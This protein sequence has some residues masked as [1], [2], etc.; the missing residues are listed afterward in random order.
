VIFRLFLLSFALAS[1]T[2]HAAEDK[3]SSAIPYLG[4]GSDKLSAEEYERVYKTYIQSSVLLGYPFLKEGAS[5]C[6][7]ALSTIFRSSGMFGYPVPG[8]AEQVKRSVKKMGA[9]KVE[10]FETAGVIIQ[11]ARNA[12]TNALERLLLVNSSSTKA[13]RRLS[14]FAKNELL[15]LEKDPI[16][17]LEKVR[18]LPVGFPHPFL[19]NEGQGLFVKVLKFNGKLEGCQPVDFQDNAWAAGFDLSE[20]RCDGLQTDA[21]KVWDAQLSPEDFSQNELKRMKEIALKAAIA[22]GTKESEALALI[23]KHFQP[24]FTSEINVVGSAMRNLAQCNLLALG[25]AGK[26]RASGAVPKNTEPAESGTGSA[27]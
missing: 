18:G 8:D 14:G 15:S 3:K 27:K 19:T 13:S 5:P 24:P 11:V 17:G 21:A 23:E 25:R 22:K 12:K 16:T 9:N 26:P 4:P 6:D 10:T 1:H 20:A 2:L 7:Q